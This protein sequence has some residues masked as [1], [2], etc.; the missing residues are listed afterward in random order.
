MKCLMIFN[1]RR[2]RCTKNAMSVMNDKC[3]KICLLHSLVMLQSSQI[4]FVLLESFI[5]AHALAVLV[6]HA[7][8][9]HALF[10]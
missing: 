8:M 4:I 7:G 3:T 5:F 6:C 9:D 1:F 10:G 2:G